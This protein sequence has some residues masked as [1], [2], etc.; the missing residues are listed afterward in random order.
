EPEHEPG[1]REHAPQEAEPV[2]EVCRARDREGDD[3]GEE[4]PAPASSCAWVRKPVCAT[5]RWS[6]RTDWPSTCHVRCSTSSDSTMPN[7]DPA[8]SSR[9]SAT[10]PLVGR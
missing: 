4:V 5:M 2:P 3:G 9:K 8:S 7:A 1:P 10:W 6:G